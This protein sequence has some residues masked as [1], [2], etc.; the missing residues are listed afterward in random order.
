VLDATK[1]DADEVAV[2]LHRV[3]DVLGGSIQAGVRGM[4]GLKIKRDTIRFALA[5]IEATA[6]CL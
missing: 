1:G 6:A 5:L 2:V 4:E 3:C